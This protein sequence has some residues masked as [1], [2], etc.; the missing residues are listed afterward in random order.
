MS[1][2]GGIPEL[3]YNHPDGRPRTRLE[4]DQWLRADFAKV[5]WLRIIASRVFGLPKQISF[6]M[7]EIVLRHWFLD[8]MIRRQLVVGDQLGVNANASPDD[9]NELRQ[10]T[11]RLAALIQ[12]GHAVPP[13]HAE[14]VDM[15]GYQPPPPPNM[16]G[17]LPPPPNGQ[18]QMAYPPGPPQPP[19]HQP[20]PPS[21]PPMGYA[22][23]PVPPQPQPPPQFQQPPAPPAMSPP[24]APGYGP[25]PGPPMGPPQG[26]PQQT[27]P[28]RGRPPKD[29]SAAAPPAP[30]QVAPQSFAPPQA[31]PFPAG[32]PAPVAA[33]P[34]G[35]GNFA[36]LPNHGAVPMPS[37]PMPNKPAAPQATSNL[38]QKLD[39]LLSLV[40]QQNTRIAALER[41]TEILGMVN[42]V[43]ARAM[44]QKQGPQTPESFLTELEL[45]LPPQ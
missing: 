4:M 15:S 14:G 45:P 8:E 34:Q 33:P 29:Q 17:N 30:S 44:Y 32:P 28:R 5:H 31:P 18:Q 22:Q 39:Q 38:D 37:I 9:E 7:R 23:P 43:L 12:A 16:G 41:K 36:P 13:Q 3:Q 21:G 42:T 27:A 19:P 10:F 40:S 20:P 11:Q 35:P 2:S 26:A 24:M 6:T 25:P 1:N